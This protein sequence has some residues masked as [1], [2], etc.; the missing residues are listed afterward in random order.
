MVGCALGGSEHGLAP[1]RSLHRAPPAGSFIV[2]TNHPQTTRSV[3]SPPPEP[4]AAV[5]LGAGGSSLRLSMLEIQPGSKQVD[6]TT[7]GTSTELLQMI[8]SLPLTY[9]QHVCRHVD[10]LK[11]Q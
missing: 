6:Q 3:L 7:V 2:A 9:D 11:C 5:A 4:A 8:Y 1:G 10:P